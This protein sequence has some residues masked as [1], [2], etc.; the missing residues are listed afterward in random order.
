MV[1]LII[2]GISVSA[3]EGTTILEAAKSAGINIPTLCYLKEINEIGACRICCVEIKGENALFSACNTPVSEGMEVMTSTKKVL[4][5][6]KINLQLILANHDCKCPTC[7]RSGNCT[8]Q[9]LAN[10]FN[11]QECPYEENIPRNRKS[12]LPLIR[13]DSK[14]ISCLRCV[15][16]CDKVQ[17][18]SVWDYTGTGEHAKVGVR[19]GLSIE[20]NCSLCGQCVTHCP[21][22]AL[23]ERDDTEKVYSAFENKNKIT[24]LQTAPAVRTAWAES[25]GIPEE[26]ATEKRMVAAAKALGFDYVFDTDFSADLTIMEEGSEFIERLKNG[27]KFP[28]FTSCCP[29]WVRFMKAE[30]PEFTENLSTAKSPQQMFGAVAKTY[31]AQKINADPHNI[32]C[33]SV[34]PCIAK[35]QETEI[36]NLRDACGDKDV[37][38]SL[39]TREFARMIK[40]RRINVMTLPEENFDSPLGESSGAGAIFG[41]TGGVTEAALR[42]VYYVLTG[43]NPA[44][45]AFKNMRSE[46]GLRESEITVA[47]KTVRVAVT[48]GLGNARSLL[49]DI[50]AGRR[51]YDFVEIMACPGGCS[52]GGGQPIHDGEERALSRGSK[53]Y[54]LDGE[55]RMRFSHEN[56]EVK[57][58]Y[59]D[60]LGEPLGELSHRLLHTDLSE[61]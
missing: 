8:L 10:E 52:G 46:Q 7:V 22:G 17:G 35:K 34:M 40:D 19:N 9:T 51:Q 32:F 54:A 27:G 24:V 38:V 60:F 14:C 4:D 2:D 49:E 55:N 5:A 21:V 61:W 45:D 58:L 44:P 6:R 18:L 53:L 15:N 12:G 3:A 39:T 59:E 1:N 33:V 11:L 47:G 30:F 23:K 50:K 57:K 28:M 25:L 56:P 13:T 41:A 20:K 37:D 26:L 16:I 48:S 43:E 29:G 36:P 42:T 31:F